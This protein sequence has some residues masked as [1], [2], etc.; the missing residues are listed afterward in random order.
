M[1]RKIW[2][3][4]TV[5]HATRI[6]SRR[7]KFKLIIVVLIQMLLG[8]FDLLGVVFVGALGVLAVDG[9]TAQPTEGYAGYIIQFL[10]VTEFSFKDQAIIIGTLAV[11]FLTSKTLLSVFFTRRVIFFFSRR[12]ATISENLISR[13]LAEP[14]LKVQTRTIQEILFAVTSGVEVIT[15][16]ILA[17]SVNLVADLA[18]LAILL[19][20][21]FIV[22]PIVAL[23]TFGMFAF[24]GF[25]L[26]FAVHIR[27]KNLGLQNTN[28]RIK[29][30]ERIVEVF[31]SYR[32][33]VV[34]N[35]RSY[36]AREI[37]K[38]RKVL[39]E[40]LAE[41]MFI[42]YIGK[43]VIETFV[44][45]SIVLMGGIQLAFYSVSDSVGMLAIYLAS[46]SR[47]APAVL[48]LQ[49]GAVIIRTNAGVANKTLD[50]RDELQDTPVIENNDDSLQIEHENFI[51]EIC[52]SN[53]SFSYPGS[54]SPTIDSVSIKILEGQLVAIV[55]A[56]GAGKTTLADLILGVL[57][58]QSG[59]ILISGIEPQDAVG[60]WPGAIAYVPQDVA[61][62]DGTIK[63]NISLGYPIDTA[64]DGIIEFAI[65]I[66]NL[67]EFIMSLKNRLDTNVGERGNLISGG[68]RQRIGIARAMYTRPKL[69]VL[70]EATSSLDGTSE[71]AISESIDSMRGKTTVILIAHRLSTVKN[72]DIVI[73]LENGKILAADT[74]TKVREQVA[75][76]DEQIRLM[77]P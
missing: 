76:F 14:I 74:F 47:I 27:A 51:P 59:K 40:V 25:F 63:E 73:Y 44:I 56:S 58:P 54:N 72:A 36:Y 32:E 42:P 30:N 49:Q 48:R 33:S 52:I 31:S 8:I 16:N 60:K 37:G 50:L 55:G 46:A 69:L 6:L 20:G 19:I 77:S 17:T 5:G 34:R 7:D 53:V 11:L 4:S 15:L 28:I 2:K 68:Q 18:L 75:N 66:A 22:S 21:L 9:P 10:G 1:F 45:L 3:N 65:Q 38:S 62:V 64:T 13:L 29:S 57:V 26:Y 43:Y 71:S 61:I 70:D 12:G 24:I 67:E 35:R 39:A 41:S 23:M